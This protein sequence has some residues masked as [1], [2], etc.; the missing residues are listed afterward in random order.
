M[1]KCFFNQHIRLLPPPPNQ[2]YSQIWYALSLFLRK[3]HS[4][5]TFNCNFCEL[6]RA[7]FAEKKM[8][9]PSQDVSKTCS[10]LFSAK[11]GPFSKPFRGLARWTCHD[12]TCVVKHETLHEWRWKLCEFQHGKPISVLGIDWI[13]WWGSLL[14]F[15]KFCWEKSLWRTSPH[16]ILSARN[17]RIWH[18][19]FRKTL[20]PWGNAFQE[21]PFQRKGRRQ[22]G[23]G[24]P[25]LGGGV[26]A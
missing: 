8:E 10:I 3:F 19:Q 15:L 20:L 18:F 25:G 1:E 11:F 16:F 7:R 2:N 21:I 6:G 14:S 23:R 4:V 22:A 13:G 12:M 5:N 26:G 17:S 24:V 9:F